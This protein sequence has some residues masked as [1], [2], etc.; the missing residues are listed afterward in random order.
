MEGPA[1]RRYARGAQKCYKPITTRIPFLTGILIFT[2]ALVAIVEIVLRQYPVD[3]D[4]GSLTAPNITRR[5]LYD[6]SEDG[7]IGLYGDHQDGNIR[8]RMP[9]ISATESAT[10]V[11]LGGSSTGGSGASGQGS[12]FS[13]TTTASIPPA[14]SD[15]A[16]P[17]TPVPSIPS[18]PDTSF[19]TGVFT[20]GSDDYIP[21]GTISETTIP[22]AYI[23]TPPTTGGVDIPTTASRSQSPISIS[24]SDQTVSSAYVP[25]TPI[26]E[27]ISVSTSPSLPSRPLI[28]MDRTEG[29]AYN[30]GSTTEPQAAP[31]GYIQTSQ[32][33]SVVTTI[34]LPSDPPVSRTFTTIPIEYI[35]TNQ[36]VE[37]AST[38]NSPQNGGE[39]TST[40]P[41][42][43]TPT[44]PAGAGAS[45]QL[46]NIPTSTINDPNAI[47]TSLVPVATQTSGGMDVVVMGTP[48]IAPLVPVSTYTS[49]GVALV[50]MG[51]SSKPPLV[52]VSTYTSN[53]AAY[54]V[55]GTQSTTSLVPVSTYTSNGA[56]YVVLGT[57]SKTSLVPVATMTSNGVAVVVL[58][59]PTSQPTDPAVLPS[60]YSVVVEQVT[61]TSGSVAYVYYTTLTLGPSQLASFTA[62]AATPQNTGDTTSD[63][64]K[65]TIVFTNISYFAAWY[66]P[67][68]VAVAFRVLWT[69]VYNNARLMEP[70]YR[71]SSPAG[72]SGR[73]ALDN[74]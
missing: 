47:P 34:T 53:G 48:T 65:T 23:A 24:I 29:T 4:L 28:S 73:D 39:T 35:P 3:N 64:Q 45:S 38:V 59:P 5:F 15:G 21:P 20:T 49:G 18:S 17:L 19:F 36:P 31:S 68:M 1:Y 10:S 40:A 51:S 52:P 11:P 14:M 57:P 46:E 58:G 56:A 32:T 41:G 22:G 27:V 74:L 12:A 69:V 8:A 7:R 33:P 16:S 61:S 37:G 9:S 66:L 6:A 43:I 70:F 42:A 13:P 63:L 67:T 55:M 25:A 30:P 50:V 72:V 54:V 71:L 26:V 2:L 60:S 44:G 62:T